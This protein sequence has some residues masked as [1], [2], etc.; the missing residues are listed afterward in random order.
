[1]HNF[2]VILKCLCFIIVQR[3]GSWYALEPV[4]T[5]RKLCVAKCCG[6]AHSQGMY[7]IPPSPLPPHAHIHKACTVYPLPPHGYTMR[8]GQGIWY[9]GGDLPVRWH[10]Q[11]QPEAAAAGGGGAGEGRRGSARA[12]RHTYADM[13]C[14]HA[15]KEGTD[16]TAQATQTLTP[17]PIAG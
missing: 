8:G 11:Q 15:C 5:R 3:G 4:Q 17:S 12:R 13:H 2:N 14:A 9:K 1:M 16:T 10:A 7:G 6:C